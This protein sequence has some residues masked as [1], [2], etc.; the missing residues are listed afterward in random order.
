MHSLD[1]VQRRRFQVG[2]SNQGFELEFDNAKCLVSLSHIDDVFRIVSHHVL[3]E[4]QYSKDKEIQSVFRPLNRIL[5][6]INSTPSYQLFL[7]GFQIADEIDLLRQGEIDES[8]VIAAFHR[9]NM[10]VRWKEGKKGSLFFIPDGYVSN[11]VVL[12]ELISNGKLFWVIL[13]S[14]VSILEEK[15]AVPYATPIGFNTLVSED[16]EATWRR[17]SQLVSNN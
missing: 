10:A 17:I 4:W 8:A 1:E 13:R 2:R 15:L 9:L 5:T 6:V 12:Q 16:T 14:E 7:A 11:S 3:P